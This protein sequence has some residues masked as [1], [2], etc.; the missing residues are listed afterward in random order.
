MWSIVTEGK[1]FNSSMPVV[2]LGDDGLRVCSDV[3]IGNVPTEIC[4]VVWDGTPKNNSY[5]SM[6]SM[7]TMAASG[8]A[9][10]VSDPTTVTSIAPGSSTTIIIPASNTGAASSAITSAAP[11]SST[12][13]SSSG[14]AAQPSATGIDNGAG[15]GTLEPES[16]GEES[17]DESGDE[18]DDES[19]TDSIAS[20]DSDD[21]QELF[22]EEEEEEGEKK[23]EA[24]LPSV[25]A[26]KASNSSVSPISTLDD[27]HVGNPSTLLHTRGVEHKVFATSNDQVDVTITGMG[28]D[29]EVFTLDRSCLWALNW[30]VDKLHDTKR[31]DIVF[32]AFQF[33]L[34]GMSFTA[35]MQES[36]P[37]IITSLLT[38]VLATGWAG[39]QIYHTNDFR[40]TFNRVITNGACNGAPLLLHYWQDRAKMEFP[41]L[42]L[43]GVALIISG[44]LTWK[45]IKLYG[46]QTFKRV[47]ASM[48]INRIYRCVL[49]LCI[50]I[51]L[52]LFFMA[53]A[54]G[55]WID[56]LF[57]GV[58][59]QV[60]WHNTAWKAAFI[61]VLVLL[62]PWLATGWVSARRELRWPM[63]AFVVVAALYLTGFGV[64]F[65]SRTFRWTFQEWTLF[66][67]IAA[68]SVAL[69]LMAFILGIV[70]RCNFGKGLLR[71]LQAEQPLPGESYGERNDAEKVSFPSNAQPVPT[72]SA[73]F[74]KNEQVPVPTQ[75]F[76]AA[77]RRMG[78]RFFSQSEPFDSAS[79][80]WND[81][82]EGTVY[83]GAGS[84]YKGLSPNMGVYP[85]SGGMYQGSVSTYQSS[86]GHASPPMYGSSASSAYGAS[87]NA[88]TSPMLPPLAR[89]D[90]RG[91]H[92]SY[93]STSS[94]KSSNSRK[95]RW[96]ID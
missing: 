82:S 57:N 49:V 34:L 1:A 60:A 70:C 61:A 35:L 96:V 81:S 53:A 71:Y 39:F 27:I 45:L 91:S 9:L 78:P 75:M 37:H 14:S 67:V 24:K 44:I 46:W 94:T 89:I 80:Q 42:A 40:M 88:S 51:Q 16:D 29:N 56:Q 17:D 47:G 68:I 32:I 43:N 2:S 5:Q 92:R 8:T 22:E 66:A 72:Y 12:A 52:A 59:G 69:A 21:E 20:D 7:S 65:V 31:E 18:S 93:K 23:D 63:V 83:S 73:T 79:S 4:E 84:I 77:G 55:L 86:G 25:A 74:G 10:P 26:V 3:P 85:E 6:V 38:H 54:V 48:Q 19:D 90:S 15:N 33:W 58:A 11:S 50:T 28:Y 95:E 62:L 87:S 13:L 64:M 41:S 30:P 76:P 36:I